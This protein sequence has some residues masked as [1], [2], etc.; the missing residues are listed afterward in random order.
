MVDALEHL[1]LTPRQRT[2]LSYREYAF[3]PTD[4]QIYTGPD[5]YAFV[6][7]TPFTDGMIGQK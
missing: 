4:H 5:E 3:T 7:Y 1:H 6:P 2:Y